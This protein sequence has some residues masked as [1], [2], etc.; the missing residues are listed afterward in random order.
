MSAFITL[1]SVSLTTPDARPLFDGLTLS[2][3]QERTGL[4]GRNGCGKSTLLSLLAGDVSPASGTVQRAGRVGRLEQVPDETL[5]VAEALGVAVGLECLKRLAAGEGSVADAAEADWTLEARLAEVLSQTGLPEMDMDRAMRTLSGGERT[6]VMLARL[7]LAAPD[8]L[9]LDEPTNNLD[10]DG[11]TAIGD[12]MARWK[13]GVVVASHDRALLEHVDRIVELTPVGVT[14]FGGGWS[15]FKAARDAA[16]ARAE[17]ELDRAGSELKRTERDA[18]AARE[19]QDRRDK[20]GRAARARGDAPKML[21]DARA[22]RAEATRARGNDVA[23]R[24]G[25]AGREALDAARARVVVETPFH[26]DL[27]QTGLPTS[28]DLLALRD[29]VMRRGGRHLFGPLT[30]DVRGPERVAVRGA[31]GSGKT[32]LLRMIAGE[33]E[34]TEGEVRRLTERAAM[35][36]QHV[37]LLAPEDSVLDNLRRL[38]PALSEN[39]A[40]AALA[41]FAFRNTAALQPAGSLSGGE[42]LRAGMACVF[43]RAEAPELLI[44]DEPTN[45]LDLAAIELLEVALSGFDGALMVVSHDEGFLSAI[46][47]TRE[48]RL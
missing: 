25:E 4:V 42:R 35:L 34:P 33:L 13:G 26:I 10:R 15:A 23:E 29:V 31:N 8:V 14:V 44:L 36:D 27:P 37:S 2:V 40:R 22:Q 21:L 17:A 39:A 24:L 43:A 3:G 38:N 18:Q 45:H 12:L 41:R 48:V 9:L 32:T 1:N 16:R 47:V 30:L 5:S 11:R 19:K 20:T 6:R 28:R 7:L 46:G